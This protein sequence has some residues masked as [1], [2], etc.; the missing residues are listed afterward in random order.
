MTVIANQWTGNGATNGDVITSGNVNAAGNG[1]AV[2]RSASGTP[3]F[4]FAGDGF[5]VVAATAADIARLDCTTGVSAA[6]ALRGQVKVTVGLTPATTIDLLH[7]RNATASVMA[8]NL[9]A[10]RTLQFTASGTASVPSLAPAVAVGDVLLI[11]WA[12]ALDASPTVSNGRI[13]YRVRN[14]TNTAWNATGEF[15]YDTLYTANIG[16]ATLTSIRYGKIST[17][18]IASPGVTWE[19]PGWEQIAVAS[20][21][22]SAAQA[23]A[24]FADAPSTIVQLA[25][26]VVTLSASANATTT[27]GADGTATVSWPAVLHAAA[28]TVEL[29]AGLSAVAGF[30]TKSTSATS[31]FVVTGL[32]A[33]A[34][35]IAVTATP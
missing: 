26:P 28:Y 1:S 22:V 12:V 15:F 14:L 18:V 33:G 34:Y 35:T 7:V 11:D 13:F 9:N 3:T 21:D 4:V 16:V 8:V 23:K 29:A 17:G 30:A 6:T 31:P 5:N 2:T 25:T 24:Y 10:S 32:S 27:G 19:V 20:T